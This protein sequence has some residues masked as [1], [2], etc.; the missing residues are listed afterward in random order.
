MLPEHQRCS[1]STAEPQAMNPIYLDEKRRERE[2]VEK[3]VEKSS[4]YGNISWPAGRPAGRSTN[5][6]VLAPGFGLFFGVCL[7]GLSIFLRFFGPG[8][9]PI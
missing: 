8:F 4:L 9:C 1:G 5:L 6:S 2:K 7:W 3:K